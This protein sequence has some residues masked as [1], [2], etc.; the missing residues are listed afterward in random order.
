M[1]VTNLFDMNGM[2]NSSQS[3]LEIKQRQ[4]AG[5][6]RLVKHWVGPESVV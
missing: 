3:S 4:R 2:Q 5:T 1:S 6:K